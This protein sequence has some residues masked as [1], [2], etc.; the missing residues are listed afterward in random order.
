[1]ASKLLEVKTHSEL[2]TQIV[3]AQRWRR[4]AELGL[5]K[6]I[7]FEMLLERCGEQFSLIGVDV[8]S[9]QPGVI[10]AEVYLHPRYRHEENRIKC[11]EITDRYRR[12]SRLLEMTTHEAA[13]VVKDDSID[14]VFIDANHSY[15][16]VLQDLQD[17]QPKIRKKGWIMGH[18]WPMGGVQKAVKEF[19][20]GIPVLFPTHRTWAFSNADWKNSVGITNE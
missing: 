7:T 12:R 6:G 3:M 4:G 19:Y 9:P 20:P 8:F 16:A 10:G 18:D 15:E 13:D 11:R 17:W 2:L 1:M 5:E 14:F